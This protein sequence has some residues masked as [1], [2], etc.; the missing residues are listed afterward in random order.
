[1]AQDI[2][3]VNN[4][5]VRYKIANDRVSSLKEF[6]IKKIKKSITEKDFLALD[7][8]SFTV[9]KG[10]V[11]GV[12]GRNGAGKSTLLKVVSGIQ[13][14]ASGNIVLNGR[15]V[16]ML[17]LG[18]GFD[19]ELSGK[20]NVYLNG[21]VLGYSKEF[22]DEK[23]NDILEFSELGDFINMPVRNYSSGM[24]ARLAFSIASMVNPEILIVDEVLSVGDEN[25]QRKSKNRMIE[26]MSGGSTVLFV[27]HN[28]K[29]IEEICNKAVWLEHGKVVM[30]GPSDVVCAEYKKSL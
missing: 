2:I 19:M 10:D 7:N 30:T 29:Q 21:A 25:F 12:V 15:V 28:I 9:K 23:Y 13:K 11:V 20:E 1:M 14:P 3:Q 5:T 24:V 22:L 17:E 16:P 8:V 4:I 6:V 27:S 18:A 26:L